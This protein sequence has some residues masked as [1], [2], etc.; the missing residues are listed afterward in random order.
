[1]SNSNSSRLNKERNKNTT[2]SAKVFKAFYYKQG[3]TMKQVAVQLNV[4]RSAIT[5]YVNDW[6]ISGKM[7]VVKIGI[8]PI[9]KYGGV[10]FLSTYQK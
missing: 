9:T 10:Q 4:E 2:F 1:M 7:K 6:K 5:Q 3:R 8:C